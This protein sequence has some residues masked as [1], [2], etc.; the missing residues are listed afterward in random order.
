MIS[1]N[2]NEMKN[3][4]TKDLKEEQDK[5][6]EEV[7]KKHGVPP[8]ECGIIQKLN[9]DKNDDEC[10]ATDDNQGGEAG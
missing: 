4:I 6:M 2:K 3:Y 10:D 7:L 9:R 5:A 1:E 8:F